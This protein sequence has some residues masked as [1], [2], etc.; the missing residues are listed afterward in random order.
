[1]GVFSVVSILFAV[2]SADRLRTIEVTTAMGIS[3]VIV[4]KKP[5]AMHTTIIPT[6]LICW[7]L[8]KKCNEI[9][10]NLKSLTYHLKITHENWLINIHN[11]QLNYKAMEYI[12]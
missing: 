1:M 3:T 11:N 10:K 4:K 6:D 5:T 8:V 12:N 2:S 9:L 7:I